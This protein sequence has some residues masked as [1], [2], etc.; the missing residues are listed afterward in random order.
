MLHRIALITTSANME[1]YLH[2]PSQTTTEP[3]S[4][5]TYASACAASADY[6]SACSCATVTA[7]TVVA[8]TPTTY[9]YDK[10]P[11]CANPAT[12]AQGYSNAACGGG[13]GI[14]IPTGGD[15]SAGL[16]IAA[17][18]CGVRCTHNSECPTGICLTDT[19]CGSTCFNP[20]VQMVST[21]APA[22]A[23]LVKKSF[24][25]FDGFGAILEKMKAGKGKL[26]GANK[27][28]ILGSYLPENPQPK[29]FF[30]AG[31]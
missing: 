21:W 14:C 15:E 11:L 31:S 2:V 3:G 27:N 23:K 22:P 28:K 1:D 29:K 17:G 20:S 8:P 6:A 4:I 19:C 26:T 9:I 18:N 12:C 5:P 13:A 16:C 7:S 25:G 24:G 10:L 30:K